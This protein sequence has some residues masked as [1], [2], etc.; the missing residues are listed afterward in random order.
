MH[1]AY[2]ALPVQVLQALRAKPAH[3]EHRV[4][5]ALLVRKAHKVCRA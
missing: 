3:R 5:L 4:L 1:R 2:R